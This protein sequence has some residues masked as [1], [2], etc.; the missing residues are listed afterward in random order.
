MK[1]KFELTTETKIIYGKKLYRIKAL[2]A[3]GNVSEGELGGWIEKEKNLSHDGNAWVY[4]NAMVCDD[5]RV[6]GNA[7]VCDDADLMWISKIGSRNDTVTFF[8]TKNLTIGVSVGCFKGT[9]DEFEKKVETTHGDNEH[10]QAYKLA[11][12]L[13][14]LRIKLK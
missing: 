6:C 3:F 7:R 1:K 9:I 5:A 13:A 10:A 12:Q 8:K 11:I 4:D 14:K 2:I